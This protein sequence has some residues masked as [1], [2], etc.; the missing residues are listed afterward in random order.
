MDGLFP[1]RDCRTQGVYLLCVGTH[2]RF[3]DRLLEIKL[4]YRSLYIHKQQCRASKR[5]SFI[6]TKIKNIFCFYLTFSS[7]THSSS[8]KVRGLAATVSALT[9]LGSS[10]G[11]VRRRVRYTLVT[12]DHLHVFARAV[13]CLSR[14]SELQEEHKLVAPRK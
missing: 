2:S 1:K 5:Q 11:Q 3:Q 12:F 4:R 6:S 9:R 13:P 7:A 10:V 8:V 14:A